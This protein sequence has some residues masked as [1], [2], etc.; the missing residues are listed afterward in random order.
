ML[1]EKYIKDSRMHGFTE[2]G[3]RIVKAN[4]AVA[5]IVSIA[6]QKLYNLRNSVQVFYVHSNDLEQVRVHDEMN[7]P[8]HSTLI[9]FDTGDDMVEV[10]T[11][12]EF[13]TK[14]LQD[15]GLQAMLRQTEEVAK[16]EAFMGEIDAL[17][18][19][20]SE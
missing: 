11:L 6:N 18:V 1:R 7:S 17:A 16:F 15:L 4:S 8:R 5:A 14:V 10:I 2:A 9:D 3:L 19:E 12:K 13:Y 20:K